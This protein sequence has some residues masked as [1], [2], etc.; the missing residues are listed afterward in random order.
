[1][2]T[3]ILG[4]VLGALGALGFI[5]ATLKFT[6]GFYA[7]EAAPWLLVLAGGAALATIGQRLFTAG[8]REEMK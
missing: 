4:M 1:M 7:D 3:Q 5:A 2:G 8:R 6:T